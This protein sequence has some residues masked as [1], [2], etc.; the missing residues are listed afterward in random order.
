MTMSSHIAY[1]GHNLIT[2]PISDPKQKPH[3]A[4]LYL[5]SF[6]NAPCP[7]CHRRMGAADAAAGTGN[8]WQSSQQKKNASAGPRSR[9]GSQGHT[10]KI[11]LS[12]AAFY[13]SPGNYRPGTAYRP[14][15]CCPAA[16]NIKAIQLVLASPLFG[17]LS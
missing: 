14:V 15:S 13:I 16:S 5:Y 11:V 6:R 7:A 10:L 9:R 1:C 2:M 17:C 8:S 3:R 4:G 12:L